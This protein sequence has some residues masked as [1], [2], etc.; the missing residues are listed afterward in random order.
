MPPKSWMISGFRPQTGWRSYPEIGVGNTAS[1]STTSG[2]SVFD[3]AT[4][5]PMTSKS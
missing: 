2:E 1:E 5:T 3:G 4:E